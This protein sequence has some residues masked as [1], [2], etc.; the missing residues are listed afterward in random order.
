M[1]CTTNYDFQI[2]I[3]KCSQPWPRFHSICSIQILPFKNK[4]LL[5]TS[6]DFEL[7][8]PNYNAGLH[9]IKAWF[10]DSF[11]AGI[12]HSQII[13]KLLLSQKGDLQ[14]TRERTHLIVF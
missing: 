4:K 13:H 6:D 8:L 5:Y 9:T 12:W 2:F 1:H 3:C 7:G 10:S 11:F 14:M